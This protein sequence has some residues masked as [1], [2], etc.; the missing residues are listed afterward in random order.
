ME[1]SKTAQNRKG[2]FGRK[3]NIF[4]LTGIIAALLVFFLIFVYLYLSDAFKAA[5]KVTVHANNSYTE[6][7]RVVTDRNYEPFSYIDENGEYAGLDV[8]LI[9]EIANRLQMNLELELLDWTEANQ[10]FLSGQADAILNMETDSVV[11]DAR[12]IATIPTTEKQY[13]AYGREKIDSVPE[14]YGKRVASLHQ[15]P[16]LGLDGEITYLDSYAEIFEALR[17]G[18]YDF[19]ICPIQVGNVF[20]QKLEMSD[21][22]PSYA[23]SHIYGAIALTADNLTLR[24]RLNAAISDM[25]REGRLDELDDKWV[26][27]H[28]QSMSLSAMIRSHPVAG[29][30]FL[31]ALLMVV[32][33]FIVLMLQHKSAL[34]KDAYTERLQENI[35][36]INRQSKEL[37]E[38]KKRAEAS[39]NAKTTFLFNMS[40]DIRTLMNA[41]I[42]YT[43]LAQREG[44][45]VEDMRDYLTKIE[46]SS[47]HLLAL[48]NDVLEMSRIESGKME[49]EPSDIDLRAAMDEVRDMFATQMSTK[50]IRYTV[51][52]AQITNRYVLC[53]KNRLNRILLNLI[54]NA[55]K[56][57][58]VDGSC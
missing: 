23:V 15:M 40:H 6:T 5:P 46:S 3:R 42:G 26:S 45:S 25:Q 55:Y 57:T 31:L 56:F 14:L 30:S 52:S 48:I 24:N 7:L 35:E 41:I 38:A 32:F 16:E 12:M 4:L 39:S 37:K 1:N 9:N 22:L 19:A 10:R 20:L 13:V 8:E 49:L 2:F 34:E 33:L 47:Q 54:S 17:V 29:V 51:D 53:D 27:Y 50:N 21:V 58:P 43:G 18:K 36:T 11:K 44:N 28:Y